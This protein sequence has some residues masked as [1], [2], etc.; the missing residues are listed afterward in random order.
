MNKTFTGRK[1]VTITYVDYKRTTVCGILSFSNCK[2]VKIECLKSLFS[3][4]MKSGWKAL[5]CTRFCVFR[6][7]VR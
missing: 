2:A 6:L 1:I 3:Y 5:I 7:S 4:Y